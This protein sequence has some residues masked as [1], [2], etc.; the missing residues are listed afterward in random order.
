LL[1]ELDAVARDLRARLA[2][3]RKHGHLADRHNRDLPV[4]D[5]RLPTGWEQAVAD[6]A[7]RLQALAGRISEL[8][9]AHAAAAADHDSAHADPS[10][11]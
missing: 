5:Q 8:A 1:S 7:L 11:T 9:R 3:V 6:A 2:D 4:M 10:A